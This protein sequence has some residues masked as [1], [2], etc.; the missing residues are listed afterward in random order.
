MDFNIGEKVVDVATGIE[1]RITDRLYSEARSQ[2]LYVIKPSDG[3]RSFTRNEDE[4]ELAQEE[5]SYSIETQICDNLV[6]VIMHEDRGG[7]RTEVCRGHG[8]IIHNGAEGIAQAL[9]YASKQ[10][11]SAIDSGIY[12]KDRR[13]NG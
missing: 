4:I 10:A 1:G 3:G 7:K 8:H 13:E 11:F 9:S 6:L 5:A 12:W 2:H